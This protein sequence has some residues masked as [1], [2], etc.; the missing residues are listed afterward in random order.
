MTCMKRIAGV[1]GLSITMFATAAR[2]RSEAKYTGKVPL[3]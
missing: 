3:D 2:A 1:V